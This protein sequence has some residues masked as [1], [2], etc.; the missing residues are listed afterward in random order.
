MNI[1]YINTQNKIV[2]KDKLIK[3][4]IKNRRLYVEMEDEVLVDTNTLIRISEKQV[5]TIFNTGMKIINI[6]DLKDD[7]GLITLID[8]IDERRFISKSDCFI[9]T[10]NS[11]FDFEETSYIVDKKLDFKEQSKN[12]KSKIKANN[13]IRKNMKRGR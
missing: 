1:I 10:I 6:A 12:V 4:L 11:V 8:K 13:N 7:I 9:E 5:I 3:Y 2:F